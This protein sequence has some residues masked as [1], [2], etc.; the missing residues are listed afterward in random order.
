MASQSETGECFRSHER[1]PQCDL[2]H[3]LI[4]CL[5][6]HIQ[7]RGTGSTAVPRSTSTTAVSLGLTLTRDALQSCL[8]SLALETVSLCSKR[9]G[10]LVQLLT[11][12]IT[13]NNGHHPSNL[14]RT[15]M[16]FL[17][18]VSQSKRWQKKSSVGSWGLSSSLNNHHCRW[19]WIIMLNHEWA[20]QTIINNR[21]FS[22]TQL[23]WWTW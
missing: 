20:I 7:D 13:P 17:R 19:K 12:W 14:K 9:W 10:R 11:M 16:W 23:R 15:V 8:S 3:L 4:P 21:E 1:I 2:F 18:G 6:V 22:H 5:Y